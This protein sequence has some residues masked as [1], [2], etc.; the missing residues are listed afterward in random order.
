VENVTG[1]RTKEWYEILGLPENATRRQVRTVYRQLAL[2]YHPDRNKS[3]GA[4]EKFKEISAAYAEACAILDEEAENAIEQD[5]EIESS[6]SSVYQTAPPT[7]EYEDP[8]LVLGDG[9]RVLK[10]EV[11]QKGN[12]RCELEISLN[13]VAKGTRKRIT[14]TQRSVCYFCKGGP[15]KAMCEH[16]HG[17]GIKEDV[18]EI[19]LT[20]PPG[21]QEG[22]QLKLAGRGHFGGDIYVELIVKPHKLFQRD[23]DDIYC[24]IPLSVAQLRRG[25]RVDIRTLDGSAASLRIPAK[26]RKG[27]I[28]VLQGRGLTRWGSSAKGDLMVK[29][30]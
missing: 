5:E 20:I 3:P 9:A 14:I 6:D 8:S 12:V 26:T 19:P 15:E 18:R 22:M 7:L 4:L 10:T 11:K 28:F 24:E 17:T 27:T 2:R 25:K 13:E 1:T 30:V 21:V 29:I 23:R 16:C